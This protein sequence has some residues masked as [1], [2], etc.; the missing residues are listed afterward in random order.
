MFVRILSRAGRLACRSRTVETGVARLI[1]AWVMRSGSA[2]PDRLFLA[3]REPL[4]PAQRDAIGKYRQRYS[5]RRCFIVGNGPSLNET[6]LELLKNEHTFGTNLIF[7]M[8]ERNGFRPTFYVIEDSHVASD[9]LERIRDYD[10]D[11]KFIPSQYSPFYAAAPG[12]LFYPLDVRDLRAGRHGFS[13]DCADRVCSG[14]SVTYVCLQLA[15]YMGFSE[16]YLIGVDFRYRKPAG[17]KVRGDTWTSTGPDPNHFSPD[18]FGPGRKWH[19]PRLDRAAA[20]F[21]LARRR[22]DELGC[23]VKNAT[24]G[25]R[26]EIFER[27]DYASLFPA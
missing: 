5:G 16:V 6:N 9:H 7:R 27:V 24:A 2:R 20:S 26:L 19:D 22:F 17:V 21:R 18:Y 8:T 23:T 25:G 11:R 14:G 12:A 3:S 13:L 15:A 4:T 1:N 10:V